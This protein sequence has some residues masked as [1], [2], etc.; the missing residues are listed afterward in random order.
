M[1]QIAD[2]LSQNETEICVDRQERVKIKHQSRILIANIN[3]T[4]IVIQVLTT[5]AVV[6]LVPIQP[7]PGQG[8]L[9]HDSEK[10]CKHTLI[11]SSPVN[12]NGLDVDFLYLV[13]KY[14]QCH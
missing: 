14:F 7:P 5:C 13:L 9:S 3:F 8:L 4:L 2:R 11:L 6:V 12:Y 10:R 1:C